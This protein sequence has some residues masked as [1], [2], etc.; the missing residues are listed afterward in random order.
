MSGA[1]INPA[2]PR[3]S[4]YGV[5]PKYILKRGADL[6]GMTSVSLKELIPDIPPVI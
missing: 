3:N 2:A 1:P 5:D 6:E 4:Q